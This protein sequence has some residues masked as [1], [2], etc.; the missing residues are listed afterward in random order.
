MTDD[1]A[2]L[3]AR[4]I[5]FFRTHALPHR[6]RWVAQR[7]VDR[8]FWREA[9]RHAMLCPS[10]P[11]CYGGGGGTFAHD[12][13]VFEAQ[14]A[15]GETGFGNQVHSG[16][17]AHYVLDYGTE[18]QKQRWLP[19][20]AA[21]ELIGAFAMTEASGGSDLKAIGTTAIRDG[22]HYRV[23]G[24]KMFVSNGSQA[25]LIA[26]GVKT[27][28]AAGGVEG[29]SLLMLETAGAAGFRVGRVLDKIGLHAQDTAE[30]YFD[31][32]RIPVANLLGREGCGYRYAMDQLAKERLM[33]ACCGV[34]V[35][36]AAVTEAIGHC[37]RP[38][39][40]GARLFDGQHVRFELADCATLARV[41][42]VFVDEC[43]TRQV[44]G[45]LD[46]QTASMA[47]A[48][49]TETQCAVVARCLRVFDLDA[50][51]ADN[52]VARMLLD[53][54]AQPIYGGTNEVMKELIARAL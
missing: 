42:R 40:V 28:H 3:R 22:D 54:R 11:T 19:P 37:K 48:W 36:E 31:D 39:A 52:P 33:V 44:R 43:V 9:G 38:D 14:A 35:M 4:A 34:A 6:E 5:E 29:I 2:A 12:R 25:D 53:S 13:A 30:L 45:D 41:A 17:V 49:V 18:V 24:A 27:D 51:R 1:V 8:E 46:A 23:N 15:C 16:A 10:V 50:C 32:V 20:M 7:H 26:L 21:G 47:K